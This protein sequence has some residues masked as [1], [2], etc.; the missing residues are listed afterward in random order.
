MD[1]SADSLYNKAKVF[2]RRAH[3]SPISSPQFGFWMS[4]SQELLARAS[5]AKLHPVLL[6]DPTTEDNIHYAFGI[7]P[8]KPPRSIQAKALFARCSV[9]V[10]DFTDKMSGHCLILAD[11][12]NSELH[13]GAASFD[14]ID[15]SSWLPATYEVMDVLLKHMG[16]DF[17]DFLGND[18]EKH[19]V[20]VLKNRREGIKKDVQ[21]RMSAARKQFE[22]RTPEWIA[23]RKKQ[24]AARV[25]LW[26]KENSK[27]RVCKCPACG[28]EAVATGETLGRSPVEVDEILGTIR[29]EV[30]VLPNAFVC[31][32][33]GLKLND[34]QEMNEAGLGAIYT[35]HEEE[36]PIDFFGIIPE[37]HVDVEQIIA[38]YFGP[39]YENE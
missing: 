31:V 17:K 1:W 27:R 18:H 6:A 38:N 20:E 23:E 10:T 7:N 30:R 3:D 26:L 16:R 34:F 25:E 13:S 24:A 32:F 21:D 14:G 33:C 36:D 11:R 22:T 4:L 2:A 28:S 12:R 9:Y 37:E 8:K 35:I 5:L 19:A 39:E 29:R 15:N